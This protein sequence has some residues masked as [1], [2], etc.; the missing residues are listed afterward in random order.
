MASLGQIRAGI[1]EVLSGIGGLTIYD[2]VPDVT[3]T[4]AVVVVP[5]EADFEGAMGRGLDT[6]TFNLFVLVARG[7]TRLSQEA[8]DEYVTGAGPKSIRAALFERDDLGLSDG[9]TAQVTGMPRDVPYG[10]GF[11]S[12]GVQ[13]IGACL[14]VVVR[15]PGT[16]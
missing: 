8:L 5:R 15:T 10:G 11:E 13:H 3:Q 7:E 2:T 1:K 9:T 12:A 14:R 4:P 16:A 6:W